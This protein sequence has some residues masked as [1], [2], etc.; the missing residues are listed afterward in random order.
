MLETLDQIFIGH[1]VYYYSITYVPDV[2]W[3]DV[4]VVNRF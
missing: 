2:F 4:L 1:V 3:L